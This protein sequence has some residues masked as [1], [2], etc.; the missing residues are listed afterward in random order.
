MNEPGRQD[1][2]GC[3]QVKQCLAALLTKCRRMLCGD[4]GTGSYCLIKNTMMN[5]ERI[6][7]NQTTI[8]GEKLSGIADRVAFGRWITH[9]VDYAK[10]DASTFEEFD[11]ARPL[12]L[13]PGF[14]DKGKL[15]SLAIADDKI[16]KVIKFPISPFS[17]RRGN[18]RDDAGPEV[19]NLANANATSIL[20]QKVLC[21]RAGEIFAF[22]A[23]S[24]VA[25]LFSDH[26]AR[27][28]NVVD[29]QTAFEQVDH[30]RRPI[31]AVKAV[32]GP[33]NIIEKTLK[34]TFHENIHDPYDRNCYLDLIERAWLSQFLPNFGNGASALGD[35][36]RINT[37]D[38]AKPVS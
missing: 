16:C 3:P 14:T 25:G 15:V 7:G 33:D 2:G 34:Q 6:D 30:E 20:E 37:K 23:G 26:N 12:G 13:A 31:S 36:P 19:A 4:S 32:I 1:V 5:S 29:L 22:D 38:M 35:V 9:I 10:I 24:L 27:V 18:N 17:T 21:R 28:I 11:H 8:R